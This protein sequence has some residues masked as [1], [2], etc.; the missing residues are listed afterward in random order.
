M[1]F[2]IA[3]DPGLGAIQLLL[4]L[5]IP[6]KLL[7]HLDFSLA[8][9]GPTL[10]LNGD[11][12]HQCLEG[13]RIFREASDEFVALYGSGN[14]DLPC[15]ALDRQIG[16]VEDM[17]V[18]VDDAIDT[19]RRRGLGQRP[20]WECKLGRCQRRTT[21]DKFTSTHPSLRRFRAHRMLSGI[22]GLSSCAAV[23]LRQ[24]RIRI[25]GLATIQYA[26]SLNTGST[27][28]PQGPWNLS[29][30]SWAGVIPRATYSSIGCR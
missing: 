8:V 28:P 25:S 9:G 16:G 10:H 13:T 1:H 22:G 23:G 18:R 11:S 7:D 3:C 30:S 19:R 26:Y 6:F 29:K 12:V 20:C 4:F 27:L 17:A 2:A 24:E 21:G 5:Q 14:H 15:K